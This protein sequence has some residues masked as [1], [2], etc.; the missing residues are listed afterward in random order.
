AGDLRVVLEPAAAPRGAP[1]Q[2][3]RVSASGSISCRLDGRR[4][5]DP[6][7]LPRA[8]PSGLHT[9]T[10]HVGHLG[11]GT[12]RAS[13]SFVSGKPLDLG[14]VRSALRMRLPAALLDGRGGARRG[15]LAAVL[16]PLLSRAVRERIPE[17]SKITKWLLG[18]FER[19]EVAISIDA[20]AHALRVELRA[21]FIGEDKARS[22]LLFK[23]ALRPFVEAGRVRLRREGEVVPALRG[24]AYKKLKGASRL[25]AGAIG[26]ILGHVG[27]KKGGA[28]L[29]ILAGLVGGSKVVDPL[30][31]KLLAWGGERVLA[32]QLPLLEDGIARFLG[33]HARLSFERP[34]LSIALRPVSVHVAPSEVSLLLDAGVVEARHLRAAERAARSRAHG[35]PDTPP[36]VSV[37]PL[38]RVPAADT[39]AGALP[40]KR[41]ARSVRVDVSADL[42]NAVLY[43]AW[44][45]GTLDRLVARSG[46]LG[47]LSRRPLAD[48]LA[49][50]LLGYRFTL[51]PMLTAA[52]ARGRAELRAG[53]ID[54]RLRPIGD[55][56][57]IPRRLVLDGALILVPEL[58]AKQRLLRLRVK[59][60]R[61]ALTCGRGTAAAPLR[62]CLDA[63]A[64]LGRRMLAR[65]RDLAMRLSLRRLYRDVLLET[66]AGKIRVT[67]AP[68]AVVSTAAHP[69]VSLWLDLGLSAERSK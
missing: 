41:T 61:L 37:G 16:E 27:A 2:R 34:A 9:M 31:H 67:L 4:C 60:S 10:W 21:H 32:A 47:P 56:P 62:P 46:V 38:P 69:L 3:A 44:R 63:F 14:R 30:L 13:R 50:R 12:R 68:R 65:R 66:T 5:A 45:D 19:A 24:A 25:A 42:V 20:V 59:P 49:F 17:K 35:G 64:R 1:W 33:E 7:R 52:P 6:A 26:G 15:T 39:R 36:I 40:A 28:F 53:A 22:Q 48:L 43:A 58:V 51:P 54:V 8:L 57:R 23:L 11:R 18:A 55:D 29:G